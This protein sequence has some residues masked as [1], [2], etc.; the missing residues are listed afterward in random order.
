MSLSATFT[1]GAIL[2]M[3]LAPLVNAVP[4]VTVVPLDGG[5]SAYPRYDAST[6]QAG[7]FLTSVNSTGTAIDGNNHATLTGYSSPGV[8]LGYVRIREYAASVKTN[9]N[10]D[11]NSR[12]PRV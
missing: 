5:C 12:R 11:H 3:A 1:T 10:I 7:P 9:S 4:S 2:S 8:V 6:G